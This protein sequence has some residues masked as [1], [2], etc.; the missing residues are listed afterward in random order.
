V[1]RLVRWLRK[2]P[3]SWHWWHGSIEHECRW[4]F[5]IIPY[6]YIDWSRDLPPWGNE[7]RCWYDIDSFGIAYRFGPWTLKRGVF[8]ND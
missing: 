2:E 4:A 5:S 6:P 1:G 8:D 3:L 7:P